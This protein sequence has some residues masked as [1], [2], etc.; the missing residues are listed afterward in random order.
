MNRALATFFML[1]TAALVACNH[2]TPS[3]CPAPE[4]A[5]STCAEACDHMI[6]LGCSIAV[7][8]TEC[9]T[10]CQ[11]ATVNVANSA[12]VLGCYALATSCDDIDDCSE[13]CGPGDH[14]VMFFPDGGVSDA[15][16]G[17]TDDASM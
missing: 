9:Q 10:V 3:S 11:N 2:S 7:D 15:D 8:S 12:R 17:T 16:L 1:A 6:A 4:G 13:T 14:P 5:T